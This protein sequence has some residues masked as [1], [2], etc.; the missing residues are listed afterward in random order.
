M[1]RI[2]LIA[3]LV[4]S[5][6]THPVKADH[7]VEHTQVVPTDGKEKSFDDLA[8]TLRSHPEIAAY[9]SRVE[10]SKEYAQ[11]EL[12]LPDPMV[13]LEQ[14]DYRFKSNMGRGGGDTMI[15]FRQAIPNRSAREARSGRLAAESEKNRLLQEY[16]FSA[17]KS[18]MIATLAQIRKIEQLEKIVRE[19]KN[20][21]KTE[22]RS[23]KGGIAANRANPSSL[24]MTE[25]ETAEIDIM[26]AELDEERHEAEAMLQNMLG[27]APRSVAL[28]EMTVFS[29]DEDSNATYPVIIAGLDIDIA[30]KD[31]DMR[32][33]EYGPNFEI[34]ASA[35][36]MDGGDQG[37]SIMVGVSIPLWAADSQA[38]RLRGAK[39]ALSAT[40]LDQ[41]MIRRNVTQKL[42]HL[43][44]QIDTSDQKIVLLGKKET[45]LQ[46][47]AKASSREY[48]AGKSDFAMVLKAKREAFSVRSQ[49]ITEEARRTALIA[50][51]NHYFKKED[52]Q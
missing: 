33:A 17:M 14:E 45:L 12:G 6:S 30:K 8:A 27:H 39:A 50:E 32:D 43:K 16:A 47:V 1:L 15:G 37:G 25:A 49:R 34:Q 29:W 51:F 21:L 52:V 19:Q 3:L 22:S 36:R 35:G 10:A 28:P 18:R 9:A 40:R 5:F 31:V 48:E 41:D 4:V 42:V 11:G 38:P 7:K 26:L 46:D 13:F 24:S 20:L 23:L 2:L 44:A